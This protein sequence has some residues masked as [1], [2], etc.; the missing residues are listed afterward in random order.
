[1]D[2]QELSV[3]AAVASVFTGACAFAAGLRGEIVLVGLVAAAQL[4][5]VA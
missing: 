3:P 1:M 4:L 2:G 5:N